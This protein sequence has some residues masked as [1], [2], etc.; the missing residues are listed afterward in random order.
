MNQ[1]TYE[2]TPIRCHFHSLHEDN[3]KYNQISAEV[4]GRLSLNS[5]A[6]SFARIRLSGLGAIL[7]NATVS[8]HI[9]AVIGLRKSTPPAS[10]T[11]SPAYISPFRKMGD[12]GGKLATDKTRTNPSVPRLSLIPMASERKVTVRSGPVAMEDGEV[13]DCKGQSLGIG[14]RLGTAL[15]AFSLDTNRGGFNFGIFVIL[16]PSF[17]QLTTLCKLMTLFPPPKL[18]PSS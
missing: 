15:S 17:T 3:H 18:I 9:V 5:F 2:S 16:L 4:L 10:L 12:P 1:P 11:K 13:G 8:P 14:G 7:I 6:N